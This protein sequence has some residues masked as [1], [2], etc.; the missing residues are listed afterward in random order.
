MAQRFKSAKYLQDLEIG[1]IRQRVNE[2]MIKAV[3]EG[4]GHVIW[5][6]SDIPDKIYDLLLKELVD[7]CFEITFI[8]KKEIVITWRESN[9]DLINRY[10]DPINR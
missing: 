3:K 2:M 1:F 10:S 8:D 5:N 4:K 7:Q 9:G 6:H